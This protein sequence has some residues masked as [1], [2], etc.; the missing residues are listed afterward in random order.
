MLDL[1]GCPTGHCSLA[2]AP[3]R[4]GIFSE[5]GQATAQVLRSGGDIVTF[6]GDVSAAA[7]G[8]I[9]APRSVQWQDVGRLM[10][11]AGA[12]GIPIVLLINFL[13][14][15]IMAL[16][17]APTLSRFG[18][19]IFVA[20]LVGLS[21][22]RELAPLMTAIIVA[23]RSGAAYAAELGTMKVSEEIDAL[24]TLGID[25][26]R[27]LVF[28]RAIALALVVPFLVLL[29][30]VVGILGGLIVATTTL[31]LT[32]TAYFTEL[33]LAIQ[34]GDVIGGLAKSSVF[35]VMIAFVSCQRGLATSGGAAGVGASTTSAIVMILFNL[36]VLD[37]LFTVLYQVIG[38]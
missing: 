3:T 13:I 20:D 17:S 18:A 9:R 26:Q 19:N 1:Y 29:A 27:Y 22:T 8:A 10:E 21:L 23:G 35:A 30:D 15:I 7:V 37:A 4:L 16:Q 2:E 12:D 28:P 32:A 24:R 14:G 38:V 25:P 11:R 6:V 34:P 36:V 31:D 33:K 5:V